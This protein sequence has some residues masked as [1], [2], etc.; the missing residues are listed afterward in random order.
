[1]IPVAGRQRQEGSM[2]CEVSVGYIV[3]TSP[4]RDPEINK[5][6]GGRGKEREMKG[7]EMRNSE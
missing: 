6:K 3:T 7:G 5:K 4:A 1:M 2:K